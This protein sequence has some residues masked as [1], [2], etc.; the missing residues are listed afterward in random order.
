MKIL[1]SHLVIYLQ[2]K[3]SLSQSQVCVS[4]GRGEGLYRPSKYLYYRQEVFPYHTS[5]YR[6]IYPIWNCSFNLSSIGK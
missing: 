4:G 1:Q 6:G 5:C 2:E 3:I